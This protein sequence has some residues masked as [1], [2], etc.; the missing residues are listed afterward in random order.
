MRSWSPPASR[1]TSS[2]DCA[3][4][5]G[6]P[7]AWGDTLEEKLGEGGM[8]TVYRA[9]HALLR[10]RAAIKLVRPAGELGAADRATAL[11]RFEREANATA[12][13]RSPHTIELYDFGIAADGAFYYVMELLDGITL[14][15]AVT[16]F[17]PMP[18]ARV[19]HLLLQACDSLEEAH[20]AGLVHRDIKPANLFVC[21]YGLRDDFVKVL[22]FGLVAAA[23][24]RASTDAR[25]T[26]DHVTAGTPTYLAPESVTRPDQV[27]GRADIYGLGGVA[28][29][30]LTGRPPFERPTAMATILAHVND[31]PVPPS[32]AAGTAIPPGLEELVLD[33]L[34]KDP[35]HRPASAGALAARLRQLFV[36][37][38]S[39]ADAAR[40]WAAHPPA[41][42]AGPLAPAGE[43]TVTVVRA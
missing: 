42:P 34:A 17:G 9:R 24:D 41:A 11:Q 10:R 35:A 15:A 2:T 36:G 33:C 3:A 43:A 31:A 8:G 38:W 6:R 7:S 19:V 29:W 30:L 32:A 18:P 28:Y 23:P 13:L 20:A 14:D 16:R 26:A 4:R 22:D 37:T 27:D 39:Q 40:W 12:G 5:C 21:R 25:L 1:H